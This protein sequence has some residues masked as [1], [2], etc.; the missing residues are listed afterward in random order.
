[1]IHIPLWCSQMHLGFNCIKVKE[2]WYLKKQCLHFPV[3]FLTTAGS[4]LLPNH[5]SNNVPKYQLENENV[6]GLSLALA[7]R[8][9][10][11][12]IDSVM[13]DDFNIG[14]N[15]CHYPMLKIF[16]ATNL[17]GNKPDLKF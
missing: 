16:K 17:L 8:E 10:I 15:S 4:L 12:N 5:F 13:M 11:H 6:N 1:M 7:I 14:R 9:I 3:G 2:H